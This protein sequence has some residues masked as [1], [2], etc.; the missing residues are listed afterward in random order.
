MKAIAM[1]GLL[2]A[3]F[4]SAAQASDPYADTVVSYTT[5]S[6]GINTAYNNSSAALGGVTS[7]A[8]VVYPA[9]KATDIVGVGLGGELTLGFN[10]PI[11][12]D[13]NNPYGLD[14]TIFGNSFFVLSSGTYSGLYNHTGLTVWVS[15]DNLT[16]YLLQTTLGADDQFPTQATGDPTVPLD[17]SLTTAAFLGLTSKTGGPDLYAGSAGGASYDISW[18]VDSQGNAVTLASISYVRIEGTSGYGYI[19][20]IAAVAAVPEPSTCAMFLI[21]AGAAWRF[22]KHKRSSASA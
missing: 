1:C 21:G 16:Y 3:V 22:L 14:F 17:P 8:T 18:A 5:G 11:L 2:L 4:F 9:W 6:G 19:D 20:A 13:A 10:E 12:N 7:Y 15:T